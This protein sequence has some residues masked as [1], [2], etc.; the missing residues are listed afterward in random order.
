MSQHTNPVNRVFLNELVNMRYE[1]LMSC[2][3]NRPGRA[4]VIS[5]SI[6]RSVY[7]L[8]TLRVGS[9]YWIV[10][11]VDVNL[12]FSITVMSKRVNGNAWHTCADVGVGTVVRGLFQGSM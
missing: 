3:A 7:S 4:R 12:I 8:C 11:G 5:Y 9:F 2:V 6:K 1:T 10:T